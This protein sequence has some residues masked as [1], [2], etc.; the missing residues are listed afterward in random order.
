MLIA[1]VNKDAAAVEREVKAGANP[2]ASFAMSADLE[3]DITPRV[4]GF[5]ESMRQDGLLSLIAAMLKD[6]PLEGMVATLTLEVLKHMDAADQERAFEMEFHELTR[7]VISVIRKSSAGMWPTELMET[8]EATILRSLESGSTS[9]ELMIMGVV[10]GWT[11]VSPKGITALHVSC[12]L[13]E[14]EAVLKTLLDAGADPLAQCAD[15]RT[16]RDLLEVALFTSKASKFAMRRA[17]LIAEAFAR[18]RAAALACYAGLWEGS[19][20]GAGC[21]VA[22]D[23]SAAGCELGAGGGEADAAGV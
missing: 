6:I 22:V 20:P 3:A 13:P 12:L 14:Q 15:G 23:G 8:V 5:L 11:S 19:S 16:A 1:L 18:R 4:N 17:L 10:R 21:V 9:D 2:N 7:H